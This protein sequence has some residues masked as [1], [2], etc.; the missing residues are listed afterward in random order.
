M[1]PIEQLIHL[2]QLDSTNDGLDRRL[3]EIRAE[4][5]DRSAIQ[6]VEAQLAEAETAT[7]TAE[8]DQ[9]DLDLETEQF[10]TKL[11]TEETKLY[12]GKG[13][14]PKELTDLTHE[15]AQTKRLVAQREDQLL[16]RISKVETARAQRDEVAATLARL[17]EERAAREIEV[18]NEA[19]GLLRQQAQLKKEIESARV[20]I[21]PAHLKQYDRLR[22]SR[23]GL[24]V[25]QI[26]QRICQGCRVAL[27][28]RE[29]QRLRFDD[30]VN[31]SSCGR[32]LHGN[33]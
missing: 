20:G 4:L 18:K 10:R 29:E 25:V 9:R 24:A 22:I 19:R 12:S 27:T 1:R 5:L 21:E 23:D 7:A 30:L 17:T 14:N 28:T 2:Q 11:K 32:I 26:R 31:C 3:N 15:V 16:E 13:G 6:Q 8:A 33:A